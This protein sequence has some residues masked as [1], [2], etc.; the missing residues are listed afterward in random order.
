MKKIGE[1]LLS[2]GYITEHELA[3]ALSEQ[4]VLRKKVG[5]IFLDKKVIT[6]EELAIALSE[7]LKIPYLNL[8]EKKI[9]ENL[10]S[11][12]VQ[13]YMRKNRFLPVEVADKK[14]VLATDNP[15]NSDLML[16]AS[17]ITNME[18]SFSVVKTSDLE[19]MFNSIFGQ[20]NLTYEFKEDFVETS[21]RKG[22]DLK[23]DEDL[24]SKP[25]V[26]LVNAIILDAIKM[27]A[28]D[29]HF[30]PQEKTL[31]VRYRIDGFLHEHIRIPK[32]TEKMVISRVKIMAKMDI[33]QS[34][35]PQ[36]GNIQLYVAKKDISLRVSTLPIMNGE[37]I[38]IRILDKSK[39][40]VTL[41]DLGLSDSDVK[42][43]KRSSA[44]SQG[45]ILVTGPTGSGK[46]TT[47]YSVLQELDFTHLNIS[48][49]EDPIEYTIKGINQTQIDAKTGV[50][51]ASSLRTLLRQD[52]NIVLVGE[53]R[54][55][56]T[57]STAFNAA[58]TGHLILST[59]HTNDELSTIVRLKD[60]GVDSYLISDALLLVIAQRLV[61]K[62]CKECSEEYTSGE[63]EMSLLK[64]KSPVKLLRANPKGCEK[65]SFTGYHGVVGIYGILEI[66]SQMREM[67]ER[68]AHIKELNDYLKK[69]K[70]TNVLNDG[71]LK[72][73]D[74]LTTLEEVERVLDISRFN[75]EKD[76]ENTKK[77]SESAD[78]NSKRILVVDDV[79]TI[80]KM[81]K[82]LFEEENYIVGEAEDGG[83]ALEILKSENINLVISDI[84]MPGMDGFELLKTMKE[85]DDLKKIPVML[86][87][88]RS[89]SEN[90]IKGLQFG[91]DDYI[92]KPIDPEKV[93]LRVRNIFKRMRGDNGI[94]S[95]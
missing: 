60:L 4:S 18:I 56:E 1:I 84:S 9:S 68:G 65:C 53:I 51:F 38:V 70:Y 49:I 30:E 17:F 44:K 19:K 91:A 6:D 85:D 22:Q 94:N 28:S 92:A 72:A 95:Q 37:K 5:E 80:R 75:A 23:E 21:A 50:T 33:T 62:V 35:K 26:R 77:I 58:M 15:V 52:P 32:K 69:I 2:K 67:I 74:Q 64:V 42:T 36:D 54:D 11:L 41:R 61:R 48:T 88:H 12:F 73:I 7:Q 71:L 8:D 43:I 81:L 20:E 16:E 86:L 82:A 89:D 27:R 66:D 47:L 90:E 14:L 46:T 87:T 79:K 31:L 55:S 13:S 57:A 39:I 78:P 34:R 3:N 59:V 76:Y 63:N 93:L 24:N 40:M 45:L 10:L 25:I 83:E 29:I